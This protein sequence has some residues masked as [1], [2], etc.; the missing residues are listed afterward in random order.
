[1]SYK[2]AALQLWNSLPDVE[3]AAQW[4][5]V[6]LEAG[7][8][9]TEVIGKLQVAAD[10]VITN[11]INH[12]LQ[13]VEAGTRPIR[14]RLRCRPGEAELEI[15]DDGPEFDPTSPAAPRAA[16]DRAAPKLGGAGLVF[17]RGLIDEIRYVRQS[18]ENRLVL[19]LGWTTSV[20]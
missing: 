14:L 18:S 2:D 15:V 1:M 12:G 4:L 20:E 3:R 10:E 9:P 16:E 19:R 17:M 8:A 11:I 6:G 5:E 13:N 7:G